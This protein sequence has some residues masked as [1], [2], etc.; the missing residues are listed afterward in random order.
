MKKLTN[1]TAGPRGINLKDGGTHWVEP[2]AEIHVT[3]K[4]DE[5]DPY[6]VE[7][8]GEKQTVSGALP[9]FG[10][11]SDAPTS[12]DAN[13]IAAVQAE[14]VDLKKQVEEQG[15]QIADLT[16]QLADAKK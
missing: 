4:G 8:N 12:E 15:K 1:H 2:G 9:D 16:K 3:G 6:V 10:K 5:K 7:V 13:L 14:N 11:P